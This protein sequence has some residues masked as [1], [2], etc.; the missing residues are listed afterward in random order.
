MA[1]G[2]LVGFLLALAV[3]LV[4]GVVAWALTSDIGRR[5]SA[6]FAAV[7]VSPEAAEQAERKLERLRT[8]GDTA[9]L[10]EVEIT[11]LLRY[12]VADQY[13]DLVNEPTVL[14]S[15]DTLRLAARVPSDRLPPLA[16]L[17]RIRLFL[18]DTSRIEL[19][20][21]LL[22][23]EGRR[24]ALAVEQVSFAG[25]PIPPRFYPDVLERLGRRDEPGLPENAMAV[26]LPGYVGSARVED[27]HLVLTP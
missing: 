26:P 5:G 14:L 11:S 6:E 20:G 4:I 27:G 13:P 7:R 2:R 8:D 10:N 21:R 22:P 3:V 17:E 19:R 12:R 23:I 16:E 24:A 1:R 25:I 18:P 9:R 15:G